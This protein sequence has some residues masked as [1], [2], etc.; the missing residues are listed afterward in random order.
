M[1]RVEEVD[2][3]DQ[4]CKEIKI[5]GRKLTWLAETIGMNYNTLYSI[6]IQK[7]INLS[8]ENRTLINNA[9]GTDF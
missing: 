1:I 6:L 8:E 5:Q 2:V 4:L 9:L 7:T 3:R